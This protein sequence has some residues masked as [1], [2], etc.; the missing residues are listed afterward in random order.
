MT[1]IDLASEPLLVGAKPPPAKARMMLSGQDPETPFPGIPVQAYEQPVYVQ[2]SILGTWVFVS[3]PEGVKRVLLDNVANYPKTLME[4]RFFQAAFGDGLL[5]S[6]GE[7]W[8][9]HRRTMAPAFAPPSVA[10]YGP[11]MA[12]AAQTFTDHWAGLP[13]G[14]EVDVA[15]EM[16]DLTLE[17][18]GLTMFSA[19]GA[20]SARGVETALTRVMA[21]LTFNPLFLVPGLSGLMFKTLS[22][23]VRAIFAELDAAIAAMIAEREALGDAAPKD[24]LARLIAA[25]DSE[26]GAK[27][28]AAEVRDEVVTI[29]LA[30]HETTAAAMAWVWYVLSQHPA[31]EARLHEELDRVLG[32]RTPTVADLPNLTYA[33][34]VLDETMRLY[35]PAPG[36]SSRL[37]VE[38]DEI[39]G[40]KIPKGANVAVVPWIIHRHRDLWD[41]PERFDPERFAPGTERP[42]FAYVP[43]SGGPRVCIGAQFAVAE[44]LLILATVAQRF[45]LELKPG[46]RV[47][48]H[49]RVT[50]RP[51]GGLPMILRPRQATA[52]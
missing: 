19:G 3:D 28:T 32:G 14:T 35:P 43:F 31:V 52:S 47:A 13:A 6:E 40:V 27:M 18:I 4:R 10:A 25:R 11:V 16:S 1:A 24:L 26:T 7:T 33:R 20:V 44:A 48:I 29:F 2:R 49:H 50:M 34:M 9:A 45:H 37:A 51:A 42:R 38:A 15:R 39:C 46:H 41:R 23:K 17:I 5:S 21:T 30:G 22:R 8:R 12:A 36:T